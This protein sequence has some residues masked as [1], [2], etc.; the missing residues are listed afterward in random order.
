MNFALV[1]ALML[2]GTMQSFGQTI[3][4]ATHEQEN[5]L[6]EVLKSDASQ[7]EKA[8]ACR[9]LA[10]IGTKDA[11][12]PLSTLLADEK[13]SHMARYALEPIPDPA[14][15]DVFRDALGK[16]KGRPLVGVIGSI[17]VRRDAKA[18][19][20]LTKMLQDS[21][22]EVVQAAARALGRISSSA[23]AKALQSA[24]TNSPASNQPALCEGLFRCAEALAA[25][26]DRNAAIAIYDQLRSLKAPR[27]IHAGALR[28]AILERGPAGV[29]LLIEQL[30]SNDVDTFA[31]ALRVAREMPDTEV[32]QSLVAELGKLPVAKR[33]LVVQ[34]LGD[35]QDT[36]A[37]PTIVETARTGEVALRVAALKAL[38]QLG[39][40]TAVPTLFEAAVESDADVAGAAKATLTGFANTKEADAAILAMVAEGDLK[41]RLVAIEVVAQRR[42]PT[43][44]PLL[45]KVAN[46]PDKRIRIAA[47]E[48]LGQTGQTQD[49][50]GVVTMLVNRKDAGELRAAEDAAR[51][52]C[53]RSSG[54]QAC[55]EILLAV[56]P[57]ANTEAKCALLRL[58]RVTGGSDALQAIRAAAKDTNTQIQET[59]IRALCEWP[60]AD[61]AADLLEMAK[62]SSN[63][64]RKIAALRGYINLIRDENLST[65]KKL[66]MC[67]EATALVQRSEEKRFLLGALGTVPAAEALSIV[68]TYIDDSATKNE[69]GLAAV[70]IGEKTFEQEPEKVAAALQKVIQVTDNEDLIRSAKAILGKV[71]K[72]AGK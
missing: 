68:M 72:S 36:A 32:T 19:G 2:V 44:N 9:Q 11:I 53:G 7:K 13:L 59:A 1:I 49:L 29:P 64:Q 24:L 62:A 21:D 69:A 15:D 8:D 52:I 57:R 46:D 55:A 10:V 61:A 45:F 63:S 5:K 28:G 41:A 47:I 35:R 38:A 65:E 23:A 6:I 54:K 17:G 51:A 56:M 4:P 39:S 3:P 67:R 16:L 27:Q 25:K 43:G 34:A 12:L 33:I 40:A 14:V 26:G 37:L 30:H 48:A 42:T 58:L 66:A 60:T 70:A 31:I 71:K 18:V 22:T 50:T 20:P